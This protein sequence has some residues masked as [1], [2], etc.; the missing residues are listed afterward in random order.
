M[1]HAVI[2]SLKLSCTTPRSKRPSGPEA[3][4][5]ANSVMTNACSPFATYTGRFPMGVTGPRY[6]RPGKKRRS[7]SSKHANAPMS[8]HA[9][10]P[11]HASA[12]ASVPRGSAHSASASA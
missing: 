6:T 2:T 12:A 11:G 8:R 1:T 3:K 5:Y 4:R 7:A 9:S 10:G